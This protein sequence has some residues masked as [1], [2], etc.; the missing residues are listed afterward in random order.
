MLFIP[1]II[2]YNHHLLL[3]VLMGELGMY[4]MLFCDI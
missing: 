3:K 2:D 1:K 4:L